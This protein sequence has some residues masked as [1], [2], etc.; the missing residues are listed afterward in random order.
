MEEAVTLHLTERE[1]I[2][3]PHPVRVYASA[4][5]RR[6]VLA[7]EM[8]FGSLEEFEK[9]WADWTARPETGAFQEK[10]LSLLGPGST[11]EFWHLA[12]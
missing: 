1:K 11:H 6:N 10:L 5:G 2:G 4:T 8:E 3:H 12:E 9:F 7:F